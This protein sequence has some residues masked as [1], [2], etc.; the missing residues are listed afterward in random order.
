MTRRTI[1]FIN[2]D[3]TMFITPEFNGDRSEFIRFGSQDSC[4]KDWADI[5]KEFQ[6]CKTLEDFKAASDRAQRYYHSC[7]GD[8][9]PLPVEQA[10]LA[11]IKEASACVFAEGYRAKDHFAELFQ[12]CDGERAAGKCNDLDCAYCPVNRIYTPGQPIG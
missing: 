9:D 4:D 12:F 3:F 11:S 10:D 7:L 8:S 1:A 6:D 5:E 2:P